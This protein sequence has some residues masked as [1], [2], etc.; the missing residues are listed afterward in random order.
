MTLQQKMHCKIMERKMHNLRMMSIITTYILFQERF[1]AKSLPFKVN[2]RLFKLNL[3][4]I[5]II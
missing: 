3:H 2:I 1:G 4:L 5:N